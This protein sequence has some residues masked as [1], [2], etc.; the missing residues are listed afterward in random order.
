MFRLFKMFVV[1]HF[2]HN[3][4]IQIMLPRMFH[5]LVLLYF[6]IL[7]EIWLLSVLYIVLL[8]LNRWFEDFSPPFRSP[9]F[10]SPLFRS[11][12]SHNEL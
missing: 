2:I 6:Y 4:S 11:P 10:R 3:Y 8:A 12:P 7:D 5:Y 9:L 1:L